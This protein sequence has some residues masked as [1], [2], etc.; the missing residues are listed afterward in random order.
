MY[1]LLKLSHIRT[2][3]GQIK[4]PAVG[5]IHL[6]EAVELLAHPLQADKVLQRQ[7]AQ[8]VWNKYILPGQV[9]KMT[10][11]E[12]IQALF[13]NFDTACRAQNSHKHN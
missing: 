3:R 10:S 13:Y 8:N 5:Q 1:R 9:Q 11:A 6:D 12:E 4:S 2:Y 7:I